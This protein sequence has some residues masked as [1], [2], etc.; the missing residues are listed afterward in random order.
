MLDLLLNAEVEVNASDPDGWTALFFSAQRGHVG[1]CERLLAAAADPLLADKTGLN[2]LDY[3]KNLEVRL[4]LEKLLLQRNLNPPP[5]KVLAT[6]AAF[7]SARAKNTAKAV[8]KGPKLGALPDTGATAVGG[9]KHGDPSLLLA[10]MHSE[11]LPSESRH[12]ELGA[13]AQAPPAIQRGRGT[14]S[15]F[16]SKDGPLPNPLDEEPEKEP[17]RERLDTSGRRLPSPPEL[18]KVHL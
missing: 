16:Q 18:D 2:P 4:G 12:E 14:P 3:A 5:V 17:G 13:Q 11:E 9:K 1:I 10:M 8:Q 15:G 7:Q 6:R